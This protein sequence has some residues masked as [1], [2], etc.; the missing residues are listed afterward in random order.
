MRDKDIAECSFNKLE[1]FNTAL[2]S[3]TNQFKNH[4]MFTRFYSDSCNA[5]YNQCAMQR[6]YSTTFTLQS[7]QSTVTLHQLGL[8][9]I[10]KNTCYKTIIFCAVFA[11]E[12]LLAVTS[13]A[14]GAHRGQASVE[15]CG[16]CM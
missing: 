14:V 15:P 11:V 10:Y 16:S 4:H 3:L 1:K 13:G 6:I 5:A 12:W 9:Q 7:T 8:I 2:L